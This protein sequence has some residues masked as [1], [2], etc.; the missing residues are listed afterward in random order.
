MEIHRNPAQLIGKI[1]AGQGRCGRADWVSQCMASQ[2]TSGINNGA[3]YLISSYWV[4]RRSSTYWREKNIHYQ[5]KMSAFP[6]RHEGS[7]VTPG[8]A[9]AR[10]LGVL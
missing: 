1:N 3:D 8:G 2:P 5:G 10:V 4:M 9:T 6:M 7:F